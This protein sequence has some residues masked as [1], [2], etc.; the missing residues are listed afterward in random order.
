MFT[1]TVSDPPP[2]PPPVAAK[3]ISETLAQGGQGGMAISNCLV[4]IYTNLKSK[5]FSH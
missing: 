5:D 1:P 3:Q 2:S 4:I